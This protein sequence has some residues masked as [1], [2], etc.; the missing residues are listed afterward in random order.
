MMGSLGFSSSFKTMKSVWIQQSLTHTRM[1]SSNP[2]GCLTKRSASTRVIRDGLKELSHNHLEMDKGIRLTLAPRSH[3]QFLKLMSHIEHGNVKGP[4]SPTFFG[5]LFRRT[6][7]HSCVKCMN[8]SSILILLEIISFKILLNDGTISIASTKG[9]GTWSSPT[10]DFILLYS[11]S[12][13]LLF[14]LEGK[15]ISLK[16]W[17]NGGSHFINRVMANLFKKNGIVHKVAFPYHSQTSGQVEIS[18]SEI[19]SIFQKT[20]SKTRKDWSQKFNDA[21][22]AYRTVFKRP[23]GTTP[24]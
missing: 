14:L 22:W 10:M 23:L 13:A 15:G 5:I 6:A 18:N 4:R 3:K 24:F 19:K 11:I 21:L 9:R 17:S 2:S 7:L 12:I 16:L 8:L 20:T 1:F